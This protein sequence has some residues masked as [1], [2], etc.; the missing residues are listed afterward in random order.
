LTN[1]DVATIKPA[2]TQYACVAGEAD[3]GMARCQ[4][5]SLEGSDR[6]GEHQD[7]DKAAR[8]TVVMLKMHLPMRLLSL[9]LLGE[10]SGWKHQSATQRDPASVASR[11]EEAGRDPRLYRQ[12]RPDS[13]SEVGCGDGAINIAVPPTLLAE[14]YPPGPGNMPISEMMLAPKAGD[15]QGRFL[16]Q[17]VFSQE[18]EKSE[19]PVKFARHLE[20]IMELMETLTWGK[21]FIYC[22]IPTPDGKCLHTVNMT[23]PTTDLAPRGSLSF[24][25]GDWGVTPI[26]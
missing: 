10:N 7:S 23:G 6:C 20:E 8:P 5:P 25:G 2:Y 9:D 13:G 18:A 4:D 24:S 15:N 26:A 17:I 12:R 1:T 22:N 14:L 16:L 19:M 21:V 3:I 11:A